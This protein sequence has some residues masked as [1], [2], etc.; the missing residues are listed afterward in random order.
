LEVFVGIYEY[1]Y[2]KLTQ[3]YKKLLILVIILSKII[4]YSMYLPSVSNMFSSVKEIL[5]RFPFVVINAVA[6]LITS[7]L[8]VHQTDFDFS[9]HVNNIL[10]KSSLILSLGIAFHF[11]IHTLRERKNISILFGILLHIFGIVGSV[12]LYFLY[13]KPNTEFAILLACYGLFSHLI[14][15]FLAF[16][17]DNDAMAFWKFNKD[18]FLRFLLAALFSGVLYAGIAGA[19]GSFDLLFSINVKSEIYGDLFLLISLIFNTLF[20]LSGVP[21]LNEETQE[22]QSYPKSLKIFTQFVLLPLVVIYL[23][24]MYA[25]TIKIIFLWDWPRGILTYMILGYSIAGMLALLLLYPIQNLTENKWIKIFSTWFYRALLPLVGVLGIAIFKR[26][27]DYGI[28]EERYFVIILS[29]WLLC[30]SLYYSFSKI[31]N[32]KYIPFTLAILAFITTFGPW[33]AFS[34]SKNSQLN[35]LE[36]TLVNNKLLSDGMLKK[37]EYKIPQKEYDNLTSILSYFN[38][39]YN[40]VSSGYQQFLWSRVSLPDS[41]KN[42]VKTNPFGLIEELGIKPIPDSSTTTY[43]NGNYSYVGLNN[44]SLLLNDTDSIPFVLSTK[45]YNY[46]TKTYFYISYKDTFAVLTK[47]IQIE[48]DVV[49][50][51][52]VAN[53]GIMTFRRQ[54]DSAMCIFDVKTYFKETSK[55]VENDKFHERISSDKNYESQRSMLQQLYT[56]EKTNAEKTFSVKMYINSING[57]QIGKTVEIFDIDFTILLK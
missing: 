10:L 35:R 11:A 8:F 5:Q 36:H 45:E 17:N 55:K 22:E 47:R 50:A 31:K 19:I 33:G 21:K 39:D 34:V 26:V 23:L 37:G 38:R 48:N 42:V 49:F 25:Y 30:I 41:I 4:G 56:L 2:L 1:I 43:K 14:V 40:T 16:W 51:T 52:Y 6:L 3:I 46:V 9:E 12:A 44:A 27:S 7:I 29:V 20:F 57:R 28:T 13:P 32:I 24:I 53:T 18:L 54:S 15:A